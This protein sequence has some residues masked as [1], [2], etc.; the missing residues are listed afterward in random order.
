MPG[1]LGRE[2]PRV[3]EEGV[4]PWGPPRPPPPLVIPLESPWHSAPFQTQN[5]T[6]QD[7]K[8]KEK[9]KERG[10]KQEL[11]ASHV[12]GVE[13]VPLTTQPAGPQPTRQCGAQAQTGPRRKGR[14]CEAELASPAPRA[15]C[16]VLP[17]VCPTETGPLGQIMLLAASPSIRLG[18][19]RGLGRASQ[20][21]GERW[22]SRD[23]EWTSAR[24]PSPPPPAA[25]PFPSRRTAPPFPRGH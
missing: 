17:R 19:P 3:P 18:S 12:P 5:K 7:Q 14:G 8:K 23:L 24:P 11:S 1:A 16:P 13:F 20:P 9:K 4:P 2:R 25:L 6:K 10:D 15:V 21:A 22:R